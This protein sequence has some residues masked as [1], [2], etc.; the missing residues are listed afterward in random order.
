MRFKITQNE[1]VIERDGRDFDIDQHFYFENDDGDQLETLV[2]N[3]VGYSLQ[4]T[5]RSKLPTSGGTPE[6]TKT[7]VEQLK[8]G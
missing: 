6:R 3:L 1:I 5:I 7:L 2:I 4:D 8:R